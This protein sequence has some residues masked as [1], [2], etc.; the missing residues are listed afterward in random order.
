MWGP[1]LTEVLLGFDARERW[2]DF[3]DDW[4]ASRRRLYLL[5]EDIEKPLSTD[6]T[7]WPSVFGEGLPDSEQLR[8]LAHP[9][10][11][12]PNGSLWDDLDVM[13]RC[14]A[15]R[16]P[17]LAFDIIAVSWLRESRGKVGEVGPY[18]ERMNPPTRDDDW[19]LLGFD[20]S[21]AG[22]SGLM[23]CGFEEQE[24]QDCVKR[25]GPHLNRHHLFAAIEDARQFR[26]FSDKR[27][28]EHAPFFILA[29][30]LVERVTVMAPE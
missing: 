5:R 3:S 14:L 26:A 7:V 21:D 27:V 30:W 8:A 16:S 4:N 20:V 10:W 22:V 9:S 1:E 2:R 15:G 17:D 18:A 13:R 6:T 11:R 25:W 23:N 28:A 12:G 29:L 24:R 19:T